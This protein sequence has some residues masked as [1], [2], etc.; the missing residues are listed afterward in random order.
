MTHLFTLDKD[1]YQKVK[2]G[3]I[4]FL[5]VRDGN[6]KLEDPVIVQGEPPHIDELTSH[7]T[8]ISEENTKG[9]AKGYRVINIKNKV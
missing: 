4:H 2:D 9:I 8:F 7:I 6:Y 3:K 1:H 5:V